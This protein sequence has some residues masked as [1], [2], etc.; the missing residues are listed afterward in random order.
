MNYQMLSVKQRVLLVFLFIV[1]VIWQNTL[2]HKIAINGIVPDLLAYF[3]VFTAL[4]MRP[5]PAM[6]VGAGIGLIEGLFIGKYIG[7]FLLAKAAMALMA[8]YIGSKFYK[9]NYLLPMIA[10]FLA[11]L[12]SGFVYIL[13]SYLVGLNLPF[14]YSFF[15]IVLPRSIYIAI[16]APLI[17][18]FVYLVFVQ[19]THNQF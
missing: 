10:V 13:F 18:L 19:P 14:L 15:C 12:G 8:S 9:E 7:L 5:I 16:P 6:A 4:Y 11:S 3:V 1:A 2:I 17:F